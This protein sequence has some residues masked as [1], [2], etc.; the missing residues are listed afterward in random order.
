M[1]VR[2]QSVPIVG[3]VSMDVTTIDVT[4]IPGA[5]IGDE[6]VLIGEQNGSRITAADLAAS[7]QTI[8]YEVL[9]NISKRVPRKYLS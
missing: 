9:C 3:K 6:V 1:L 8:A 4:K 7:T 5:Q 2:G